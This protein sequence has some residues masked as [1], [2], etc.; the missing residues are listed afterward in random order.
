MRSANPGAATAQTHDSPYSV[1]Y[2]QPE[3]AVSGYGVR[4]PT[5]NLWS[6]DNAPVPV[7]SVPWMRNNRLRRTNGASVLDYQTHEMADP[8]YM[9]RNLV[10]GDTASFF[11][12]PQFTG[13]TPAVF[14]G[15]RSAPTALENRLVE[16][17]QKQIELARDS[18]VPKPYAPAA[19]NF[20]STE[21]H[22]HGTRA[23]NAAVRA[24][25]IE[26]AELEA[27]TR[28][29]LAAEGRPT[30]PRIIDTPVFDCE[31]LGPNGYPALVGE[32]RRTRIVRD[33]PVTSVETRVST[34]V[35][36]GAALVAGKP[37][38]PLSV[39][40]PAAPA[41]APFPRAAPAIAAAPFDPHMVEQRLVHTAPWY[42]VSPCVTG[43][44]RLEGAYRTI[45]ADEFF[46]G[47]ETM[48]RVR[49]HRV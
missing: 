32:R 38:V 39:P 45:T 3:T 6:K 16:H 35:T 40:P 20:E 48:P 41:S 13:Y 22:L 10:A 2:S 29:T 26:A 24:N 11:D 43:Q 19:G 23:S 33:L 5:E 30:D 8:A 15:R 44:E 9:P 14:P 17:A 1:Y 46:G 28:A 37:P 49:V 25:A 47:P 34:F 31:V 36:T 27:R 4:E 18:V 12:T 7:N 42:G 21:S